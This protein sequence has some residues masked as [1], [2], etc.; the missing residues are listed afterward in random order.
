MKVLVVMGSPRRGNTY[1]AAERIRELMEAHGPVEFE[2]LWLRDANLLP[3][4]GCFACFAKGEESCP[5]RDDRAAIEQRL[6]EADGVIFA[7]PVYGMNV[8]GLFK[9]FVDRLSYVF[10]R[11]R[12]FDK[13]ALLLTTTGA[14]GTKETQ[15]YLHL[16]AQVWGFEVAG[17][18]GLITPPGG[19]PAYRRDENE[20]VLARAADSF[21]RA[22]AS[23]RRKSPA[24]RD[25]V[26]FHGQRGS[27]A[28][29]EKEAPVDYRYWKE[30]GWL[31][32]GVRY[33]V[34]VPVNPVYS[35]IG[36]VVE[37]QARRQV[38]KD[39]SP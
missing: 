33:Y 9:L 35:A 34:G 39:S 10:H 37:R 6:R 24:L 32:P 16:V 21:H 15:D 2:Y 8:S 27:F 28:E 13:K 29:L 7:S 22:L 30:Q 17:Q 3:C 14:L 12:F 18:A 4:R 31:E 11:P 19:V 36:R 5:N 26:I 25:V 38:R 20:R 23:G 1:R